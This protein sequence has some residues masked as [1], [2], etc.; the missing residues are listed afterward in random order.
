MKMSFARAFFAAAVF[1]AA[2]P[3][4]VRAMEC[5]MCA[6]VGRGGYWRR[7]KTFAKAKEVGCS[8]IRTDFDWSQM[9][10]KP[11]V[12]SFDK[13]DVLLR[14]A[15]NAGVKILPIL[16]SPPPWCRPIRDHL[17]EWADFVRRV[18]ARWGS[19][20]PYV[21]IWNEPFHPQHDM[22]E[23]NFAAVMRTAYA[24]VKETS[25]G[26]K[27]LLGECSARRLEKLYAHG[28][29]D[30]F[31][32]MNMHL[33]TASQT[34]IPEGSFDVAIERVRSCL[35]AHGDGAKP[36]WVTETG[37][38]T[39][40][41]R[42]VADILKAGI[43]IAEPSRKAWRV[44]YTDSFRTEADMDDGTPD[45]LALAFPEGSSYEACFPT[46]LTERLSRGDV[47]ALVLP[48][49][50]GCPREVLAPALEF[51]R[52]GGTLVDF[53]GMPLYAKAPKRAEWL[54]KFHIATKASFIDKRYPKS[55]RVHPAV[56]NI[57]EPQ[58]GFKS[59]RFLAADNCGDGDEFIPLVSGTTTNGIPCVAAA[60]YRFNGEL[61]GRA[62]IS[63]II[64]HQHRTS[65]EARQA[66]LA[67][68]ALGILVASGVEKA[69]WYEQR[70]NERG[71]AFRYEGACHFGLLNGDYSDKEAFAAFRTFVRMC[72]PGSVSNGGAWHDEA[73]V[74]H[75]VRWT[76]PDGV[77]C[78]M[79]WKTGP[80]G[81]RNLR[82][83]G[84]A[85]FFDHLGR[86]T[87]LPRD[88][89]CWRAELTG[90]PLY[91]EEKPGGQIYK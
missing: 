19:R 8:W 65:S 88:G 73:R 6:H 70:S 77:K 60:V 26:T 17:P 41:V 74:F 89:S 61:K 68:R 39:I 56:S 54:K 35:A 79:A 25:P 11:G 2:V 67:A 27:V 5:G 69:F 53:G 85:K 15:E 29:G 18:M 76:R 66:R 24:A 43:A 57:P 83:G 16:Y 59:G 21:E 64:D 42:R 72:P 45:L 91:W 78:G 14:D 7:A 82:L 81:S 50:E 90:A 52:R 32:V 71:G 37:W 28:V 38:P 22:G 49:E 20:L 55:C 31:D 80:R 58:G 4:D 23:E 63:G 48:F 46:N 87:E 40:P 75:G 34:A 86:N 3:S 84:N 36:I 62:V 10:R 47:D 9:E 12:W 51:V 30:C 33:Y 13:Y 1:A 44:V